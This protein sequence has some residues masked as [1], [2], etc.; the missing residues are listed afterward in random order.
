MGQPPQPPGRKLFPEQSQ[1]LLEVN[2]HIVDTIPLVQAPEKIIELVA[3]IIGTKVVLVGKDSG[4]WSALAEAG[5]GPTTPPLGN[6]VRATLDRVG[7][8]NAVILERCAFDG[9]E[10]TLIGLTRRAG[11]PA[12]LMLAGDWTHSETTLLQLG[13]NLL[14]AEC[15]YALAISAHVRLAT[16]RLSR[17]L[18]K[19]SGVRSVSEVAVRN[20]AR[21]V[22]AQVAALAI[23]SAD[24]QS[25][26]IT[27]THG[28]PLTLV[29][30]LRIPRGVGVLGSVFQS[31][32]PLRV[33]D[34]TTLYGGRP[35]RSRYRTN[36][37]A[38]VPIAIGPDVLGA[39]CVTD[40]T[41][42]RAF[43]QSDLSTL[44]TLAATVAL[45]L[46]RERAFAQADSYAQAAAIDP[47]SGLFNR[48]YFQA[49]LEEELQRAQRHALSVGLLMIDVD[50]FKSINDRFGHLAGD[51]VIRDIGEILRRSVRV[52]DICTR[53]GGEEF[54]VV[55][56]GS[57]REDGVRI[58]ERIRERIEAYRATEPELASIQI[59]ASVGLAVSSAGTSARDV[60][61]LADQALY[62][63]KR[64]GKN[65]VCT[66]N[67]Q[68]PT[69]R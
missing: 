47:V 33:N 36:S 23:A 18:A 17:A 44:R 29:E 52:F 61:S 10:W 48:R 45:A 54:A 38:V 60:I 32:M 13:H 26:K 46:V 43:T 15:A 9:C 40:R 22:R 12:V 11:A 35:R 62:Q 64:S 37:F 66:S 67:G 68:H 30:H 49:R 69:P 1:R 21:A 16:H 6:G 57:G 14:L 31:G 39:L 50:D 20:A 27:A 58:A 24:G 28:Y 34:V 55:M 25:L 53:F 42:G 2:A 59:T 7:D 41:D 19:A 51:I 63:A 56:P 65:Q 3:G 4:A 8:C 5:Q